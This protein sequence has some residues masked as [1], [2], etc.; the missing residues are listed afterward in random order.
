M[1][2]AERCDGY[3][4]QRKTLSFKNSYLYNVKVHCISAQ[5][6]RIDNLLNK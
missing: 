4:A 5:S 3:G 6:D 2:K 1:V